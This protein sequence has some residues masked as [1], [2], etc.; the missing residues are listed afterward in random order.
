M[1]SNMQNKIDHV[2]VLMLENRSMDNLLGWLYDKDETSLH[3]IPT[4]SPTRFNGLDGSGYFNPVDLDNPVEKIK[5]SAGV[6]NYF[7]PTPPPNENFMNMSQQ[8]F[9]L[10][11]TK[12]TGLPPEG[13]VP[14]MQGFL[15]DYMTA[16]GNT[17]EDALKLMQTYTSDNLSVLSGLARNYAVSDNYHAACPTQTWPNRAFMHAGTSLGR[18]N[19][20]P[21]FP[22]YC[23]TL[24]NVLE[25][26]KVSWKV[27]KSSKILPSLTRIQMIKLWNPRLNNHFRHVSDF[28][29]DCASNSLPA[30]SFLEPFFVLEGKD[31]ATSEHPPADVCAGEHFLESVWNAIVNSPAFERTLFILN[32]D[33]HGGCPDHVP[34]NWTATA[35]D[36]KSEKGDEGFR[37][38]R[39]GVRVPAIFASPFIA[40]NTVFRATK[41]PFTNSAVPYDHTSIIAMILDWQNIDRKRLPSARVQVAPKNPFDELFSIPA[42][43]D[44]PN[45]S[46]TCTTTSTDEVDLPLSSLQQSIIAADAHYRAASAASFRTGIFASQSE[47]EHLLGTITT[48]QEM[49][50]HFEKL[51][52]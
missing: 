33:E 17:P 28:I 10:D 7:V 40:E 22:Y 3:F 12:K 32:Y 2:V 46:A 34:P 51:Y 27:Y 8:Q 52:G 13:A 30:Y 45:L 14:S 5:A 35:P 25:D 1:P 4:G 19:N 44:R 37:F 24:F 49:V 48:E 9:G 29:K 31:R 41:D 47:T 16:K 26:E 50:E 21:Y 18:V 36:R 11:I 23:T 42:R 43:S 38:N 39:F 15:A 6:D 20:F